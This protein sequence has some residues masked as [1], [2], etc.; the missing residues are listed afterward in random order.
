M[1]VG[2]EMN[3]FFAAKVKAV[4]GDPKQVQLMRFGASPKLGGVR[5][6]T[7]PAARH[8]GLS[9]AFLDKDHG[10]V[11]EKN[12]L[13]AYVGP[14]TGYVLSFSNGL[15]AYLSGDTG[16]TAEQNLVVRC[17]SKANLADINIG[18]SG[19]PGASTRGASRAVIS[20]DGRSPT[21]FQADSHD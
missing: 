18:V 21:G 2:S 17:Y 15:V 14:P 6:T 11:L 10:E 4:G 1:L 5:I 19:K 8:N 7:V 13:T 3:S 12:G 20:G 9:G 16:I